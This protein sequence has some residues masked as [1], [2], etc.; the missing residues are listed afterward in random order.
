MGCLWNNANNDDT[1]TKTIKVKKNSLVVRLTDVARWRGGIESIESSML[2]M[3]RTSYFGYF[4]EGQSIR[5]E[6]FVM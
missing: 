6:I 2:C 4:V 1:G 3:E 5:E